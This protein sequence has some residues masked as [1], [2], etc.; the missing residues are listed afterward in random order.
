[1]PDIDLDVTV[2]PPIELSVIETVPEI[3][4]TIQP[5][6]VIQLNVED[7]IPTGLNVEPPKTIEL[8]VSQ[9]GQPGATGPPGNDGVDGTDGVDGVDGTDGVDGA[10]GVDTNYVHYQMA[11]S[12]VWAI[13]HNLGKHPAV[14]VVDSSETQVFGQIGYVDANNLTVTFSAPFSGRAYLN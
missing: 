12:A 10:P 3:D 6:E 2:P 1:M 7:P 9:A 8:K 13:A 14:S 4:L 5:P 11:P